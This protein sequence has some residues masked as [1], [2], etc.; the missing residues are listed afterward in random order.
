[1]KV[2][3]GFVS[4]SSSSSF[5]VHKSELPEDR[6]TEIIAFLE[7]VS[8]IEKERND[9]WAPS[10][11]DRGISWEVSGNY[12]EVGWHGFPSEFY[13]QMKSLVSSKDKNFYETVYMMEG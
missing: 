12:L 13:D 5:I 11:N 6:W 8:A 7:H 3:N 2:R 1:M 9:G 4:N 10:W